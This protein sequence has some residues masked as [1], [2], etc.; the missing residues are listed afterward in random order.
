MHA[1]FATFARNKHKRPPGTWTPPT[2]HAPHTA[3]AP[4]SSDKPDEP[5]PDPTSSSSSSSSSSSIPPLLTGEYLPGADSSVVSTWFWDLH[6]TEKRDVLQ[7]TKDELVTELSRLADITANLTPQELDERVASVL[8]DKEYVTS[9]RRAFVDALHKE[10]LIEPAAI[11]PCTAIPL[12]SPSLT[13]QQ[14]HPVSRAILHI[15]THHLRTA[16][17]QKQAAIRTTVIA[18]FYLLYIS[19][20]TALLRYP[21]ILALLPALFVATAQTAGPVSAAD[22]L[23]LVRACQRVM[24]GGV[25]RVLR[26]KASV[27]A[28]CAWLLLVSWSTHQSPTYFAFLC[29]AAALPAAL[30][31][32]HAVRGKE[33]SRVVTLSEGVLS[34][35]VSVY[36]LWL[37]WYSYSTFLFTVLF[38]FPSLATVAISS[39]TLVAAAFFPI[40]S[41]VQS[42]LYT[43]SSHPILYSALYTLATLSTLYHYCLAPTASYWLLALVAAG[44]LCVSAAAAGRWG[45]RAAEL[46][47]TVGGYAR[48]VAA[49]GAVWRVGCVVGAGWWCGGVGVCG[50]ACWCVVG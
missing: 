30:Q 48:A 12:P 18:L 17:H 10:A 28:C 25:V 35:V 50:A 4:S 6:P 13:S 29:C 45:E 2:S 49:G 9:I 20:T 44:V 37:S 24:V 26:D 32:V 5:P 31:C 40:L 23:P 1:R 38:F 15:L 21:F 8:Q 41:Y 36:V 7:L 46:C 3:D 47:G 33:P 42:L 22:P 14:L 34:F 27:D 39:A 16:H 19:R 11:A 43:F